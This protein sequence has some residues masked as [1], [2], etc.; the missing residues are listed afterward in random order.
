[1]AR[2]RTEDALW[3]SRV[4]GVPPR[5]AARHLGRSLDAVVVDLHDGL[6]ADVLGLAV[7]LVR[8]GGGLVLRL[9]PVGVVPRDSRLTVHGHPP[10]AIG[11]RAWRRLEA[12]LL[13]VEPGPGDLGPTSDVRGGTSEQALLVDALHATWA[14]PA[15]STSVVLAARGRG[16]SAALGLA[17]ARLPGSA[18]VVLTAG[19]RSSA[20]TAERFAGRAVFRPLPEVLMDPRPCDLL[21]VDESARLP[22]PTLQALVAAHPGAHLAFATTSEGYEGTGRGFVLRF[23]AWLQARG[24]VAE[25]RLHTP[26]RWAEGCP[27]ERD[28]GALLALD[29]APA[30]AR[31]AG[32]EAVA[33]R[34]LDRAA[35]A[36]DE[37][38]LRQVFGLL[39][40]AHYRTT[41][42]DL[43]RLLDG[44]A[45]HVHVLEAGG[46]VV[47]VNLVAEEGALAPSL[48]DDAVAG[49]LRLRG[50]ALADTL[51][52]H[53]GR[54][55]AGGLRMLRSVRIAVHPAWRRRGLGHRLAEAVHT[56]HRADLYGTLFG[57]TPAVLSFRRAQG[58]ALVRVGSARGDRTG[59]P[60]AVMVRPVSE[61]AHRLVGELRGILA[62]DLPL[63]LAWMAAEAPLDPTLRDALEAG[64]PAPRP[65][66]P[67]A[68]WRALRGYLDGP[69]TSDSVAHALAALFRGPRPPGLSAADV[70]LVRARFEDRACW[71]RTAEAAGLPGVPAA[72]RRLKQVARMWAAGGG[73]PVP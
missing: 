62:L 3:I 1:M 42:G 41:P 11:D 20:E 56:H 55:D 13:R 5:R 54:A 34:V 28:V 21:V 16:K 50:Q 33:H 36:R 19:S 31:A 51:L 43:V 46:A 40:H 29:A 61:D 30:E 2:V 12:W 44:P 57:A 35:L 7:G 65:P 17:I 38:R 52:T 9:P 8:G 6:D 4:D 39:V 68:V 25:H 53:A 24:P 71:R 10:E 73:H 49:R 22:V 14:A 70:A 63:Q 27:L 64:L 67:Q 18:R 59:E 66:G 48:V 58:Y 32:D 23:L 37:A 15:P 69:R 47:A 26:I 60:A 45:L 72:H